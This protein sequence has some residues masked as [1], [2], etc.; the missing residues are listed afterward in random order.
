MGNLSANFNR[1]EF[2]CNCGCG[3]DTVDSE[4]VSILEALRAEFGAS[5]TVRSGHRCAKHNVQVMGSQGSLHLQGR[6]AD[7]VLDGVPASMVQAK[8]E[9]LWPDRFGMGRYD[10]FTHVDSRGYKARW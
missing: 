1:E 10:S 5:I 3:C 2:K 8:F 6:A 7:I 4:L 9:E